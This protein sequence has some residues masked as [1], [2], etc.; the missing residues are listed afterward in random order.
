[1]PDHDKEGQ[2]LKVPLVE[3]LDQREDYVFGRLFR[4][5]RGRLRFRRFDGTLSGDIT[6]ISFERGDSV[7]VLLY[8]PVRDA[9]LLVRQFRFPVYHALPPPER[10]GE[11]AQKAWLI[12]VIAGV[13]GGDDARA[14]A[15][16]ETLE[17]AGYTLRGPLEHVSTFYVS[18]GGTSERIHLFY[19]ELDHRGAHAATGGA[20]AEGEDTQV[21]VIARR[22]ALAM[23][24]SGEI[25]DAKTIIALQDL[26]LRRRVAAQNL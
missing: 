16:R 21:L 4:I 17:E 8:D 5:V 24:A 10:D 7:A 3:L 6:R 22:D 23:V 14:V 1:M 12:E 15:R 25:C 2:L 19:G 20:P 11:G 9:V 18:P 13:Q 26:E